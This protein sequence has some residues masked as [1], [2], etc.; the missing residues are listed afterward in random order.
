MSDAGFEACLVAEMQTWKVDGKLEKPWP[1]SL[2][3][4]FRD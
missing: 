1:V 4:S 3:V 2:P